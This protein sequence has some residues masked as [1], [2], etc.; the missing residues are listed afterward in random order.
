MVDRNKQYPSRKRMRLE[1]FDYSSVNAYHIT[2]CTYQDRLLL[3]RVV[4]GEEPLDARCVL[5]PIGEVVEQELMALPIRYPFLSLDNYV[6][7]PNHIH[8]LMTIHET[9]RDEGR[10]T[11]SSIVQ[12]FKSLAT[13]KSRQ[14]G[15]HELHLFQRSFNDR[16]IRDDNHYEQTW[17]YIDINPAKWSKDRYY[18]EW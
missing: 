16:V 10:T 11:I 2:I 17:Y 9:E 8:A 12:S 14:V 15:Y 18:R 4:Y 1:N 3:S 5:T 6:I 13:R 7:M